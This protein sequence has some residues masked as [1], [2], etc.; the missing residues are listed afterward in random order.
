[1]TLH[2]TSNGAKDGR[3]MPFVRVIEPRQD[4]FAAFSQAIG[5]HLDNSK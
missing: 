5:A 1:M 4:C 2:Y 3:V